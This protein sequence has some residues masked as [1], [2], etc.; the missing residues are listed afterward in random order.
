MSLKNKITIVLVLCSTVQAIA[1]DDIIKIIPATPTTAALGKYG[2]VPVSLHTGLPTIKVPLTQLSGK[3]L[4]LSVELSYHAGGIK[5]EEISS[6]VGLGWSLFAGGVITREVRGLPDDGGYG[7]F[8]NTIKNSEF[9]GHTHQSQFVQNC[10]IGMGD[11]EPDIFYFNFAGESGK[12][13]YDGETGKFVTITNSRKKINY[14][15]SLSGWEIV[16]EDGTHYYFFDRELNA[17]AA[18][19]Q[20][21]TSN[22]VTG[23]YLSKIVNANRT[24]SILFEYQSYSYSFETLS[25][26]ERLFITDPSEGCQLIDFAST[27]NTCFK[28]NQFNAKRLKTIRARSGN[29]EFIPYTSQRWD[30]NGDYALQFIEI[31]NHKDELVMTYKLNHDYF[32][33]STSGSFSYLYRLRLLSVERIA[34]NS[35]EPYRSF[36]YSPYTVPSRLS[37]A[38]DFWGYYNGQTSNAHLVPSMFLAS[39]YV[40]QP[41]MI[42]GANRNPSNII[43]YT[44]MGML[45]KVIYPTGGHTAFEYESHKVKNSFVPVITN[46]VIHLDISTGSG[47]VY[48]TTFTINYGPNPL[49]GNNDTGGAFVSFLFDGVTCDYGQESGQA[50]TGCAVISLT[51]PVGFTLTNNLANRFLPNGTYT[52]TLDFST[53]NNPAT[54][55]DFYAGIYWQEVD[56]NNSISTTGG[57]R[58]KKI[59]DFDPFTNT[60]AF[61]RYYRYHIE[62]DTLVSSAEFDS[63]PSFKRFAWYRKEVPCAAGGGC[64]VIICWCRPLKLSAFS[65]Y[66]VTGSNGNVTYSFVTVLE[67][68]QGMKGKTTYKYSNQPNPVNIFYPFTPT[69]EYDWKRGLL[70][71]QK[72]YGFKN[73]QF[74]LIKK[75]TNTYKEVSGAK[76]TGIRIVP[77]LNGEEVTYLNGSTDYYTAGHYAVHFYDVDFSLYTYV[78]STIVKI[79]DPEN[80]NQVIESVEVNTISPQHLNV[81]R[82][83]SLLSDGSVIVNHLKYV[84]DYINEGFDDVSQ[85]ITLMKDKNMAQTV[86]EQS[87]WRKISGSDSLLISCNLVL[88]KTDNGKIIKEK[89]LSLPVTSTFTQS[90]ILNGHFIYSSDYESELDIIKYDAIGNIQEALGRDS[91]IVSFLWGNNGANPIAFSKG[92]ISNKIFYTSFEDETSNVSSTAMTGSKSRNT[93]YTINVP[94]TGTYK[95][96]YWKK[97]GTNPWEL[98]ETTISSATVIGGTGILIDE[99]RVH[100]IAAQMTTYTYKPGVGISSI[101]DV[102]NNISYYEYDAFNRLKLIKDAKGNIL[103]TYQYHFKE[104]TTPQ[105]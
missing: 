53:N 65:N 74:Q 7:Y 36:E 86:I 94:A 26:T 31:Y 6:W 23:W 56:P 92:A 80:Q 85:A 101:N 3:D 79:I 39:P 91:V 68:S 55:E 24:D 82:Q 98:V 50:S 76:S 96:T 42:T 18:P 87:S 66:P 43:H 25:S 59:T 62:S 54:W 64:N 75:I 34:G 57:Q 28:Q 44:Q 9:I 17:N 99:V 12:F 47:S 41:I 78:D 69:I 30:I 105:Y 4:S 71:E 72:E 102:N 89:V 84:D 77:S 22:T 19:C 51:G 37:Y 11:F 1:Q 14:N 83:E 97:V 21:S 52:L 88:P 103:K 10:L 61:Q 5:V 63:I 48:D 58:I 70:L 2:E 90:N 104:Q 49:N 100:P 32:G 67:D 29:V 95:L 13:V 8:F 81:I 15:F 35:V 93:S 27:F 20:G 40:N 16:S 38:Q 73:G 60:A 45:A 46:K 33:P